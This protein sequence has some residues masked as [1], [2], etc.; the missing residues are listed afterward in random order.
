MKRYNLIGVIC[1]IICYEWCAV[2]L[3]KPIILPSLQLVLLEMKRIISDPSFFQIVGATTVRTVKTYGTT[4]IVSLLLGI[5]AGY[6]PLIRSLL[7]PMINFLRAIPTI[8]LTI[9]LLIWFGQEYGPLMIM[10]LVIF[11]LLYELIENSMSRIDSDLSDVCKV[12]GATFLEKFKALYYPQIL[13]ALESGVQVTVGL[14]FK[15]IVMAEVIAQSSIG[16]GRQLSHEKTYLNMPAVFSWTLILVV[17]VMIFE[18]LTQSLI[19]K[20]IRHLY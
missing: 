7:A 8:S 14:S 18:I 5:V 16:I 11:P 2:L 12:F 4:F 15:V 6:V 1:L 19:K 9:I 13:L 17:L 20:M 3:D 10:G